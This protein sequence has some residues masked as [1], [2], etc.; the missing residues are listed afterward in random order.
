VKK[1]QVMAV[2]PELRLAMARVRNSITALVTSNKSIHGGS[3]L[4]VFNLSVS[5]KLHPKQML[6]PNV[7]LQLTSNVN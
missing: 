4:A 2:T 6:D 1:P 3:L 5:L 7:I